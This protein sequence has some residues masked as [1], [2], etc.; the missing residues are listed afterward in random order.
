MEKVFVS[1]VSM[2]HVC[3]GAG[4]FTHTCITLSRFYLYEEY[5]HVVI[6]TT[7]NIFCF[8]TYGVHNYGCYIIRVPYPPGSI[9]DASPWYYDD[10]PQGV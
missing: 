10:V 4:V 9:R 6:S 7:R 5:A 8:F 2:V 3:I 1:H